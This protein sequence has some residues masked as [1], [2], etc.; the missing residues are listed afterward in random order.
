MRIFGDLDPTVDVAPAHL[1]VGI[2]AYIIVMTAGYLFLHP[3]GL[4]QWMAAH[5]FWSAHKEAQPRRCVKLGLGTHIFSLPIELRNIIVRFVLGHPVCAGH[6]AYA[7]CLADYV[8]THIGRFAILRIPGFRELVHQWPPFYKKF[9]NPHIFVWQ[10]YKRD[11]DSGFILETFLRFKTVGCRMHLH[12]WMVKFF[13]VAE[14]N[15]WPA[16]PCNSDAISK[17]KALTIVCEAKTGLD[18]WCQALATIMCKGRPLP[19]D[20]RIAVMVTPAKLKELSLAHHQHGIED[21][22]LMTLK[23]DKM[24]SKI[25]GL[26]TFTLDFMHKGKVRSQCFIR[27]WDGLA[28]KWGIRQVGRPI[29]EDRSALMIEAPVVVRKLCKKV[30]VKWT[31]EQFDFIATLILVPLL[32]FGGIYMDMPVAK[33][34]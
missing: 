33:A 29:I 34:L 9:N 17:L 8:T 13:K 28:G 31:E 20:L 30:H 18:I 22:V 2:L 11:P 25:C 16:I 23:A 24:A 5:S 15:T 10:T 26:S 7:C 3:T 12:Q 6:A 14:E 27:E 1:I 19:N 21:S 32:L 4:Q